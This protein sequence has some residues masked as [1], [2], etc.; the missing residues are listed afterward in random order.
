[1]GKNQ[2]ADVV[3]HTVGAAA[4]KVLADHSAADIV[5]DMDGFSWADIVKGSGRGRSRSNGKLPYEDKARALA[6]A[7]QGFFIIRLSDGGKGGNPIQ[8]QTARQYVRGTDAQPGLNSLAPE[9]GVAFKTDIA[10]CDD[11]RKD[12]DGNPINAW[13]EGDVLVRLAKYTPAEAPAAQ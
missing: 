11:P 6:A 3:E 4:A 2:I 1:M 12:T 9:L 5:V 8:A 10:G 13:S 7:G